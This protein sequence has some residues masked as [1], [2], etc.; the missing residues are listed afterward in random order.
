[1]LGM[2]VFGAGAAWRGGADGVRAFRSASSL[3]AAG[4]GGVVA[5]TRT[6]M[7]NQEIKVRL[8]NA[9][10]AVV[11][12]VGSNDGGAIGAAEKAL[13]IPFTIVISN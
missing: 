12:V 9:L 2:D 1:M 4:T 6:I 5:V 13:G 11:A 3:V 10:G 8:M 7:L